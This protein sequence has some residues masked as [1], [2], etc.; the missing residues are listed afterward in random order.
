MFSMFDL[1]GILDSLSE[2]I[3]ITD[4]DSKEIL[5]INQASKAVYG[6][7]IGKL[8]KDVLSYPTDTT[9]SDFISKLSED[10]FYIWTHTNKI[11]GK[12]YMLRD[13][14]IKWDGK[15]AI[16]E[17]ASDITASENRQRDLELRLDME[18]FIVSCI[19][20]MHKN[21]PFNEAFNSLLAMTGK[22]LDADRVY[23]FEKNKDKIGP[24]HE[25][26]KD[27]ITPN[28]ETIYN[29]DSS[30]TEKWMTA[31][32]DSNCA[33]IEDVEEIKEISP[34]E[35][36]LLSKNGIR[37]LIAAPLENNGE[38]MGYIGADNIPK[39]KIYASELVFTAL[40]YFISSM[41][42]KE[43][44]NQRLREMSYKDTL[45]GLNNRNKFIFDAEEIEREKISGFGIIFMDLNGLKTIN[46]Q[47]GHH[48]GDT[49]IKT[50]AKSILQVFDIDNSYRVGGDEFV[51]ICRNITET[52]FNCKIEKLKAALD[53]T[54]YHSAIGYHY[55]DKACNVEEIVK[56]ADE[57]MYIDK[58]YFYRNNK[59]SNRYRFRNDTFAAISTPELLKNLITEERFVIWF[60]PRFDTLT[61]KFSG[62]EALIRFF[63]EDDIIVSPV[64]FI[65]D[66]EANETIHLIDFYVF[67]HVCEYISGWIK[68]GKTVKPVSIN[69]SHKTMMK[70]NFIENLMDIWYDYNIPKELIII[71][72]SEGPELGGVS[73]V[74]D[75]LSD[76]K[77]QGFKIAIDNFGAKYA[78]LYLF[79][80]LKFDIL[81]LDSDMVYKIETDKKTLLLSKS[82]AQIC[83][84]ENIKIVAEGVESEDGLRILIDMGCD[85]VQ[86]YLFDK[87][88]SWNRFENKYLNSGK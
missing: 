67:R 44:T 13:K 74:I 66:M 35:Y 52:E 63:D 73:K 39:E 1:Y 46:D 81:K 19:I 62:S 25:W 83:H 15:K 2:L 87:P 71:E 30:L 14:I 68:A 41:L 16:M 28:I 20:E 10:N 77:K 55:S 60:Q 33:I 4:K 38:L 8:R 17:I 50:I 78:D 54:E 80:D 85:E 9:E 21:K 27:D 57:K 58:K 11:N 18:H 40:C 53:K 24:T 45:T 34:K 42:I 51:V 59:M 26:C 56:L 49:A 43:K 84:N 88:M 29:L 32:V 7:C 48:A 12:T 82:I 36:D 6:D 47:H 69:I 22:F 3:S 37:R 5:Y 72:A 64:D 23:V 31:L 65:P 79:A 86:G 61:R 75:I 70:P 76:L